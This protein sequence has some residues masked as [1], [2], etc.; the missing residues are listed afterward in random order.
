MPGNLKGG[1]IVA[2]NRQRT[3]DKKHLRTVSTHLTYKDWARLQ[4]ICEA[5][6]TK[7][8]RLLRDYLK[9]YMAAAERRL[10]DPRAYR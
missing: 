7:P 2:R 4:M 5:E 6:G 10:F 1:E 9:H 8:Y 3:W